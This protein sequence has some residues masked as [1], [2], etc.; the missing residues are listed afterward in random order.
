MQL[1]TLYFT[2]V[3]AH[4]KYLT[5]V[6]LGRKSQV[7]VVS[8]DEQPDQDIIQEEDCRL[9]D[10]LELRPKA[11]NSLRIEAENRCDE[12]KEQAK[13]GKPCDAPVGRQLLSVAR[14]S[15]VSVK[16]DHSNVRDP[17]T[18]GR[19]H[20]HQH[21]EG[22]LTE[23]KFPQQL[24]LLTLSV[25]DVDDSEDNPVSQRKAHK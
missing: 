22:L 10:C 21:N 25:V 19:G 17:H 13:E 24:K 11:V 18:D 12:Y 5:I 4:E 9:G 7:K 3:D 15:E 20:N 1:Q 2:R 16:L 23:I 8:H 14:R 6:Y